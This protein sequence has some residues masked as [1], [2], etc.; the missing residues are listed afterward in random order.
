METDAAVE[1][2]R[3]VFP[4]PLAKRLGRFAQF[5]Q[6]R[7]LRISLNNQFRVGQYCSIKVGQFYVVKKSPLPMP[8]RWFPHWLSCARLLGPPIASDPAH[9]P[10]S[11]E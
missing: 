4:Q 6:A 1:K 8:S 2:Q 11:L 10:Q 3:T 7:R 5:P 9:R